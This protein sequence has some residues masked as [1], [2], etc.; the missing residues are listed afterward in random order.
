LISCICPNPVECRGVSAVF[1]VLRDPRS[2][3]VELPPT[4]MEKIVGGTEDLT[5]ALYLRLAYLR[6]LRVSDEECSSSSSSRSEQNLPTPEILLNLHTAA[7][8]KRQYVALHHFHPSIVEDAMVDPTDPRLHLVC[9]TI[10]EASTKLLQ[11]NLTERDHVRL[12]DGTPTDQFFVVPNYSFEKVK[13]DAKK[14]FKKM[15]QK[16]QAQQKMTGPD[17]GSEGAEVATKPEKKRAPL[18]PPPLPPHLSSIAEASANV[19]LPSAGSPV[20]APPIPKEA[21]SSGATSAATATT[22]SSATT[23]MVATSARP[24]PI[25]SAMKKD[26]STA[27]VSSKSVSSLSSSQTAAVTVVTPIKDGDSS[28]PKAVVTPRSSTSN[29]SNPFEEDRGEDKS[30]T[31]PLSASE[32]LAAEAPKAV[33]SGN[34]NQSNLPFRKA[35]GVKPFEETTTES[36]SAVD[37]NVSSELAPLPVVETTIAPTSSADSD[38]RFSSIDGVDSADLNGD[39][40]AT[41]LG[42]MISRHSS[43]PPGLRRRYSAT[44]SIGDDDMTMMSQQST[45]LDT[46]Q[47]LKEM[48]TMPRERSEALAFMSAIESKRR[49][50]AMPEL[51]TIRVE[52]TCHRALIRR[53]VREAKQ[54]EDLLTNSFQAL[55]GYAGMLEAIHNDCLLDDDGNLVT[56]PRRRKRLQEQRRGSSTTASTLQS[57]TETSTPTGPTSPASLLLPLMG[58][59]LEALQLSRAKILENIP[60]L[61]LE[62]S[63]MKELRTEIISRSSVLA[64]KGANIMYNLSFTE[65]QIQEAWERLENFATGNVVKA[66]KEDHWLAEASYKNAVKQGMALWRAQCQDL[67]QLCRDTISLD[68]Q[69]RTRTKEILLSFLPR[70]RRI[71]LRILELIQPAATGLELERTGRDEIDQALELALQRFSRETLSNY[72]RNRSSILNRSRIFKLG[73]QDDSWMEI[74]P[75]RNLFKS[76]LVKTVQPLDYK[77]GSG[78][79]PWQLALA[80]TT[81]DGS[82]HLFVWDH[83]EVTEEELKDPTL[84]KDILEESLPVES[85][86]LADCTCSRDQEQVELILEGDSPLQKVLR[87]KIWLRFQSAQHSRDWVEDYLKVASVASD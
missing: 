85:I 45:T 58:P 51:E 44:S 1:R 61:Q 57:S 2:G 56:M 84:M 53:M 16:Q 86:Y 63:E 8:P 22:T 43:S 35:A 3:F 12:A 83:E 28:S 26:T 49:C 29:N 68:A 70:R 71:F 74:P 27:A 41:S 42:N 34:Q 40:V 18:F 19:T 11:M 25:K 6:H 65:A 46:L 20:A 55:E 10:D 13:L 77:A 21:T 50:W 4:R 59:I 33:T 79:T 66:R 82:L 5:V 7:P 69:R 15:K 76:D 38:G 60:Q 62:V 30:H 36:K 54:M 31:S 52:W 73:V 14:A 23:N 32:L 67:E 47:P 37:A 80:V 39:D 64:K 48:S 75:E 78:K 72:K 9:R 17:M 24:M 81:V 87:R